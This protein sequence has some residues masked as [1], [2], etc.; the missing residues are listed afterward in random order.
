MKRSQTRVC[1]SGLA[2][3]MLLSASAAAIE[4]ELNNCTLQVGKDILKPTAVL[5]PWKM[6]ESVGNHRFLVAK[7]AVTKPKQDRDTGWT[8]KS[9]DGHCLY[10]V[11]ADGDVAYLAGYQVDK[12]GELTDYDSPPR[13]RRLDLKAGVWLPDLPL[14]AGPGPAGAST[15]W[16]ACWPKAARW[17][18]HQPCE[19]AA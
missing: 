17:S 15:M 13:L 4:P 14:V 12:D 7:D 16:S 3:A 5:V 11:A 18:Y 1:F 2:A 9:A 8:V 10:W 6:S 19:A